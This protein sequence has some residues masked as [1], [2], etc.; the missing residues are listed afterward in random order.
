MSEQGVAPDDAKYLLLNQGNRE[1]DR[2]DHQHRLVQEIVGPLLPSYVYLRKNDPVLD[3]ATG[4]GAWALELAAQ[5]GD[6]V[7]VTGIDINPSFFPP[8]PPQNVAF[9]VQ[10]ILALPPAWAGWFAGIHQRFLSGGLSMADWKVALKQMHR[11]LKPKG[12]VR[13][14]EFCATIWPA[15]ASTQ[16]L[17][18]SNQM[19]E[20]A[21]QFAQYKDVD[22]RAAESLPQLLKEAG[23]VEVSVK[24]DVLRLG[25]GEKYEEMR[26]NFKRLWTHIRDGMK[27]HPATMTD[28]EF[29]SFL[30]NVDKEMMENEVGWDFYII[31]ARKPGSEVVPKA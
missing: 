19:L 2:L 1:R 10:S 20:Y 5:Y 31:T 29:E 28:D 13:L 22:L 11:A 17:P 18:Y 9:A 21:A 16:E 3:S 12:W 7:Y 8:N 23:F 6:E 24:K 4:T 25:P 14:E 27:G 15:K 30:V 26:S